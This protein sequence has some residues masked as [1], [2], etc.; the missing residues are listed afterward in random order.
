M[1]RET[2]WGA[3]LFGELN[4]LK[5]RKF[6]LGVEAE[7]FEGKTLRGRPGMGRSNS[8]LHTFNLGL[9]F[10]EATIWEGHV[11]GSL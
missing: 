6:F 10:W 7:G 3:K 9:G 4:H 2:I 8:G 1:A 5:D 11:P